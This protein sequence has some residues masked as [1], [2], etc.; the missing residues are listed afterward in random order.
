MTFSSNNVAHVPARPEPAGSTENLERLWGS[1]H[2]VALPQPLPTNPIVV[3][4]C[5]TKIPVSP[6]LPAC[7]CLDLDSWFY[8]LTPTFRVFLAKL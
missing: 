1:Y 7:I 3:E 8:N 6:L 4:R 2:P 5:F